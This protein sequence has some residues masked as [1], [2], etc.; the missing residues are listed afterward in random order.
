MNKSGTLFIVPEWMRLTS[1]PSPSPILL[2]VFLIFKYNFSSSSSVVVSVLLP[3][4]GFVDKC[5]V[6]VTRTYCKMKKVANNTT[7]HA[8]V[9]CKKFSHRKST[10]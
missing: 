1:R 6:I 3:L 8:T 9:S 4:P 2:I 5:F 7:I 10:F